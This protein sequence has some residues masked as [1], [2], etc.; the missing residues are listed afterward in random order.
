MFWRLP[1]YFQVQVKNTQI[2]VMFLKV[3]NSFE[4]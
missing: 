2:N 4:Q 1:G 3:K